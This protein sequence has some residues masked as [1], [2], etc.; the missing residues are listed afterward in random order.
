MTRGS[1]TISR[2][3]RSRCSVSQRISGGMVSAGFA[4]TSSRVSARPRSDSGNGRPR[5]TPK[6]R[7]PAAAADDMQN[8]PL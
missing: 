5:S 8:R 7:M 4:P 1:I 6:A 2:P 3:P